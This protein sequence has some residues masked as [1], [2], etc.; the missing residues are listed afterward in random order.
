VPCL[1]AKETPNAALIPSTIVH[2]YRNLVAVPLP[3]WEYFLQQQHEQQ[4]SIVNHVEDFKVAGNKLVRE[5]K[6]SR[7]LSQIFESAPGTC[8]VSDQFRSVTSENGKT[9]YLDLRVI[10]LPLANMDYDILEKIRCT[11]YTLDMLSELKITINSV[12]TLIG[13][14]TGRVESE[15]DSGSPRAELVESAHVDEMLVSGDIAST[16][17]S[18]ACAFLDAGYSPRRDMAIFLTLYSSN[19]STTFFCSWSFSLK[20]NSC[21]WSFSLKLNSPAPI[22]LEASAY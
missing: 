21:S 9:R 10:H 16:P 5:S 13:W 7:K 11:S 12:C 17:V 2:R 6:S 19:D 15:D 4:M 22:S 18:L 14:L 3:N 20:L 8:P 1:P